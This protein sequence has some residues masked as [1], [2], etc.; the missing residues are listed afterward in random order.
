MWSASAYSSSAVQFLDLYC[1][2]R[3]PDI[4]L[5]CDGG[6]RARPAPTERETGLDK[7]LT[8]TS[9]VRRCHEAPTVACRGWE[10][11]GKFEKN[12][13]SPPQNCKNMSAEPSKPTDILI[14]S[15]REAHRKEPKPIKTE[16]RVTLAP[17]SPS[18]T[19]HMGSLW[20]L[21]PPPLLRAAPASTTPSGF[22][23]SRST[24]KKEAQKLLRQSSVNTNPASI[25]IP[26]ASWRGLP[27]M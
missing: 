27:P 10:G 3:I 6:A 5:G 1:S 15:A 9:V 13:C 18:G 26:K 24:R 2:T 8:T 25:K 7:Q 23:T 19:M 14:R 16:S 11:R 12:Y 4:Q 21:D 17:I 22:G 20:P